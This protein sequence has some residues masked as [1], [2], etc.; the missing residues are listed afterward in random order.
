MPSENDKQ[1]TQN[2]KS[3][4]KT[5]KGIPAFFS[6]LMPLALLLVLVVGGSYVYSLFEKEP[7]PEE[8]TKTVSIEDLLKEEEDAAKA[9]ST[10]AVQEEQQPE[11]GE[12]AG[13]IAGINKRAK[14]A[15]WL[16]KMMASTGTL[17]AAF[18]KYEQASVKVT[19]K[20]PAYTVKPDLSNVENAG[21]FKLTA[22]AKALL[23]KNGFAAV[24]SDQLEFYPIY[25]ANRYGGTPNFVTTDSMLHNYHLMFNHALEVLEREKLIPVLWELNK[26]MVDQ[27]TVQYMMLKGT[28][29]EAAAKRNLGFFAVAAKSL[30]SSA[31]VPFMVKDEVDRE[32]RLINAFGEVQPSPVMGVNEDYTQYAPRGHY[33]KDDAMRAYFRSMMWYGRMRFP[34]NDPESVKSSVLISKLLDEG[35]NARLWAALYQPITFMVGNGDD[36]GY[37]DMSAWIKGAYGDEKDVTKIASNEEAFKKIYETI[38]KEAKRPSIASFNPPDFRFMGQRYTVDADIFQR[39]LDRSVPGRTLPK[40]LDIAAAMGSKSAE[41]II[42]PGEE[43]LYSEYG[44]K[45]DEV[46]KFVSE[47]KP[48]TWVSNLYWGW[49]HALRPLLS[50]APEGYPSFM[51]NEAWA[52]KSLGAFLASWTE[53]KHDTILYAKQAYAE[54][55]G[56]GEPQ[57]K[58]MRG[59]VEPNPELYA[60]LAALSRMTRNGL[61]SRGLS[62]EATAQGLKLMEE[63]AN[64]LKTISEKELS[65]TALSKEEE[66]LIMSY[67][68]Q[69]EHIWLSSLTGGGDPRYSLIENPASL[70]ADV[71]TS[72]DGKVLEDGTGDVAEIFVVV[73]IDGK[74]QL[75]KGGVSTHYEFQW[76]ADD[77]LTDK[78]WREILSSDKVP[79]MA[80]WMDY[81]AK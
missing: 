75:T 20:V 79:G 7:V 53:L 27:A 30:D 5:K 55:G 15:G 69:L 78:K 44:K 36:N 14:E 67:G 37:P 45:L 73:P 64:K 61:E 63:L 32:L 9:T 23:A 81:F 38:T 21:A 2:V 68:G 18:A 19:P 48:E 47:T 28:S 29:W 56:D 12:A 74:L 58:D 41:V 6:W 57:Y 80:D 8:A 60:R 71:A 65:L 25:E 4:N 66:E 11:D 43:K 42:R 13:L 49:M 16:D 1:K 10:P 77:R 39:L 35:P 72:P 51:R 3:N 46:K 24:R 34:F 40:G 59:Y 62:D 26:R 70:V 54:M 31:I 33:D 52:R 76:P 22:E 17:P 50:A